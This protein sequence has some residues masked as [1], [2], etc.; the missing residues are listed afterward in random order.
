MVKSYPIEIQWRVVFLYNDNYSIREIAQTLRISQTFVKK[1][2]RL[3]NTTSGV[4][5]EAH[6]RGRP[7]IIKG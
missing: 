1:I 2:L 3:Y 7:R 5:Y 4:E 6:C